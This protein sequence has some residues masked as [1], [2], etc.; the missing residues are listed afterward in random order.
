MRPHLV[1]GPGDPP[2][3]PRVIDS[4]KAGRLKIVGSGDNHVDVSFVK[5]VASAHLAA[6]D[7]LEEGACVGKACSYLK[8]A[9]S[10]LALVESNF[11]WSW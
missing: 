10:N 1:F 7:A 2:L 8:E 11:A 3:L 6:L 4:V 5:D 9:C